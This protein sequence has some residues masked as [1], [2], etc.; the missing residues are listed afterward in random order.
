MT[1]HQTVWLITCI[2]ILVCLL[3]GIL[4]YLYSGHVVIALVA[5]PP[6]IHWILKRKTSSDSSDTTSY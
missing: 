2:I 5:A 1:T 4:I 6:I 3:A